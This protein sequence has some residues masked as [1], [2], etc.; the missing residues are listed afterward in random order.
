MAK[1]KPR[2][3]GYDYFEYFCASARYACQ[4]A[5]HLEKSLA[6]FAPETCREKLE[7]MH[8]IEN[9]ADG[10]RHDMTQVL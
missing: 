9:A 3:K 6:N 4:A 7:V 5:E 8:H 10:F 2:K 1:E